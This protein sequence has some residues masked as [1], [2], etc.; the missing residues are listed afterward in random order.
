MFIRRPRDFNLSTTALIER[1]RDG[2]PIKRI[3]QALPENRDARSCSS[4]SVDADSAHR[5]EHIKMLKSAADLVERAAYGLAGYAHSS[6][7]TSLMLT[8][9]DIRRASERLDPFS[10]SR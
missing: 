3:R 1:H 2:W 5:E 8:S 10:D 6:K 7:V 9:N 4:D